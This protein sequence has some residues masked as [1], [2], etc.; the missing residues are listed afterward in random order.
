MSHDALMAEVQGWLIEQSLFDADI[1]QL[2]GSLCERLGASGLPIA[3][4]ALSWPT[5][6]PLFQAEQIYWRDGQGAELFQYPHRDGPS[7]EFEQSPFAFLLRRRLP[8]LRRRLSG[9]EALTDFPVLQDLQADGFTDYLMTSAEFSIAEVQRGERGLTGIMSSW[10]TQ[11]AGG[12]STADLEA[13]FRVQKVFAV[14]C[15][16]SIQKRVMVNLAKAYLGET[17]AGRVLSGEVRRGDGARIKAVLWY[18]DLRRSTALSNRMPPEAYLSLLRDYYDCTAEAVIAEG[19]EVLQFIGDAVLGIF[20]V[21]DDCG[22]DGAVLAATRAADAALGRRA[23]RIAEA[24]DA[25]AAPPAL[26]FSVTMAVGEV[27]FGNIGVPSRLTFSAIGSA[28][29]LVARLDE[30][31][32]TL[33]RRVLTTAEVASV[34]PGRWMSLGPQALRD[35]EEPVEL[36]ARLRQSAVEDAAAAG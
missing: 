2:F 25:G 21:R 9:P 23:K 3:R 30:M 14:A 20:P 5:L 8:H 28:V 27:M 24:E 36:F 16:A 33:G 11:R 6:H 17:A 29:N 15:H 4:A 32:K 31:T 26:A 1:V 10:A 12:F 18:S 35:F 19:G 34:E 13:L 22:L 7:A